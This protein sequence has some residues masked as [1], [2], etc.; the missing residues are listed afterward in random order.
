MFVYRREDLTSASF[1]DARF[2]RTNGLTASLSSANHVSIPRMN[3]MRGP[4]SFR[5]SQAHEDDKQQLRVVRCQCVDVLASVNCLQGP[6]GGGRGHAA[7][8]LVDYIRTRES[9]SSGVQ[10]W[11]MRYLAVWRWKLHMGRAVIPEQ[12]IRKAHL[13]AF[14]SPKRIEYGR[15]W[16]KA[17]R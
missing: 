4:H 15:Q 8:I 14:T 13:G 16:A 10:V 2:Q 1:V 9:S 11:S 3:E 7:N 5:E 6:S 12:K 17:K